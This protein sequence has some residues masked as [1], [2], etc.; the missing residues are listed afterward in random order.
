[1]ASDTEEEDDDDPDGMEVDLD[2]NE[3][4]QPQDV[5]HIG[6]E[7]LRAY[8]STSSANVQRKKRVSVP[9]VCFSLATINIPDA[10]RSR[11]GSS[12]DIVVSGS[13]RTSVCAC[14]CM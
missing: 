7:F 5:D 2:K 11:R 13:V 9:A 6:D 12:R 10:S 8:Y 4:I 14:A 3:L 1:M